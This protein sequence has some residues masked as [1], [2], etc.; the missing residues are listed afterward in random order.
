MRNVAPK[1]RWLRFSL[2]T[3]LI[4][5]TIVCIWL[6]F[7]LNRARARRTAI[8]AVED[9]GGTYGVHIMGPAWL[10]KMMG[11]D[12][13]FYDAARVS[14]GPLTYRAKK[15]RPFDDDAL[16]RS[17]EP[18]NTFTKFQ[19]LDLV[20]S[21]ISDAGLKHLKGLHNLETLRLT[22][23]GVSD[24]GIDDLT[25]LKSLHR[26][27]IERTKI[28]DEGIARLKAALPDCEIIQ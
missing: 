22:D 28:T 19:T 3:L 16:R 26:L 25:D 18:L 15:D 9:L 2:R 4:A 27:Q 7:E 13:C 8:L 17:I 21:D 20:S 14:F 1:R 11:D 24:Q 10:R 5:I 23:T 6:G 12:K